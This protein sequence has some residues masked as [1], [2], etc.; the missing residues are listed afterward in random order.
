MVLNDGFAGHGDATLKSA[1]THFG[2]AITHYSP[3]SRERDGVATSERERGATGEDALRQSA[4]RRARGGGHGHDPRRLGGHP[5][6]HPAP[7]TPPLSPRSLPIQVEGRAPPGH[8]AEPT[9]ACGY[10]IA[11]F[12]SHR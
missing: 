10:L 5:D 4:A 3:R 6:F 1:E 8:H 9:R 2:H 12:Y 11:R 7:F